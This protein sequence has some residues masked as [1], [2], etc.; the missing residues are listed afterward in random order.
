M[1]NILKIKRQR[2]EDNEIFCIF[3]IV[4]QQRLEKIDVVVKNYYKRHY[5][6][7]FYRNLGNFE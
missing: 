6:I 1:K 2:V 5:A 4:F 3:V 7:Q